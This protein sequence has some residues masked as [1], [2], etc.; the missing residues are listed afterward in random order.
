MY[1]YKESFAAIVCSY[2]S[3]VY[4][5]KIREAD[6]LNDLFPAI[7]EGDEEVGEVTPEPVEGEGPEGSPPATETPENGGTVAIE[8]HQTTTT[9]GR[10]LSI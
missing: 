6:V 8:G 5:R 2:Y 3:V 7:V 9:G 10:R 4:S 1:I